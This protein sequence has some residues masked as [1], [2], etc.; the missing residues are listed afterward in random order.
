[1]SDGRGDSPHQSAG[2]AVTWVVSDRYPAAGRRTVGSLRWA[3]PT[4][5]ADPSDPATE[6][7]AWAGT[8]EETVPSTGRDL[9][10]LLARR[11]GPTGPA[12]DDAAVEGSRLRSLGYLE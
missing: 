4:R 8:P 10:T 7:V 2:Y 6:T 9:A 5:P 1:M 11:G 12:T 3:D